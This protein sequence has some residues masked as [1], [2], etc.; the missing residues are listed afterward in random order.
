MSYSLPMTIK[1][2]VGITLCIKTLKNLGTEK[3]LKYAKDIIKFK[4]V[5]CFA[6][7]ELAHGSNVKG[8]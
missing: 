3:H 1:M 2:G 4:E 5:G 8:I 7:T 6:L